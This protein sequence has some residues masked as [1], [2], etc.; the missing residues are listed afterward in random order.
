MR[1]HS[2]CISIFL[3]SLAEY[4][5]CPSISLCRA[6]YVEQYIYVEQSMSS[7]LCRTFYVE[8]SMSSSLCRAVYVEQSMSSSQQSMP[9]SLCQ[10]VYVEQSM[11]NSPCRAVSSPCRSVYVEQSMSSSLCRAVY[12]DQSMRLMRACERCEK[13]ANQP[14]R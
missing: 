3:A 1:V 2:I 8:Q 4:P 9:I 7:S 13:T 11:S 10:A 12:V 5:L 14:Q 6:F